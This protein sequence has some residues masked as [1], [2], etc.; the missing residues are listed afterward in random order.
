MSKQLY[1]LIT[2]ASMGF[3]RALAF[4]CAARKMNL[5]LVA[6]PGEGLCMLAHQ[7]QQEYSVDAVA[8]ETDLCED[9]ACEEL[10]NKVSAL[11]LGVNMLIN[12]AGVGNTALFKDGRLTDY[13]KQIRLNVLATTMI[14]RLFI[15]ALRKNAPSYVMNVGSLASFFSLS[16]KQVYGATKSYISY[17]S[18]SLGRELKGDNISVSVVCPGG[19]YTN[20][21]VCGTIESGNYIS[22]VS[23]MKPGH[24]APV[25]M[26]G[27]LK[28]KQV[29]VPGK[30]NK[31]IVFLN[32][33]LPRFVV[34]FFETRT[35]RRLHN[36]YTVID[37]S[38]VSI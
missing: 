14:T 13:E 23:S 7:L 27:L 6:L 33:I 12:N 4:E 29:I 10:F 9:G 38:Y 19:M 26:D 36:P 17:F 24:V 25:A 15:D 28:K 31:A 32:K 21:A 18:K 35:M 1:T 22:R 20:A 8:I 3:G 5:I 37:H 30:I 16:K 2:G 11:G 34:R